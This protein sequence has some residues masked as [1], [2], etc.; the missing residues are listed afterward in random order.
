GGRAREIEGS[1]PEKPGVSDIHLAVLDDS[2]ELE[3][4]PSEDPAHVVAPGVVVALEDGTQVVT[5]AEAAQ[6]RDT[7]CLDALAEAGLKDIHPKI[8]YIWRVGRRAAV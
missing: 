1:V 2:A 7:H 5:D 8:G 3:C 6:S 4:V